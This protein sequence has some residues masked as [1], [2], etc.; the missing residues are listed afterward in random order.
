MQEM[1]KSMERHLFWTEALV[2]SS[3]QEDKPTTLGTMSKSKKTNVRGVGDQQNLALRAKCKALVPVLCSNTADERTKR[4]AANGIYKQF[5]DPLMFFFMRK[6]GVGADSNDLQDLTMTTLEK[7][8]SKVKQYK[9]DQ[10]EFSTWVYRIALN[11]LIDH[12]RNAKGIDVVSVEAM[13]HHNVQTMG[14][15]DAETFEHASDGF[16]PSQIA[17]RSQSHALVRKA[18]GELKNASERRVIELRF[19]E[20]YTY[21]EIAETLD[22]P[23][24]TVKAMIF[25]AKERLQTVLASEL[26]LTY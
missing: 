3:R 18:I 23:M 2:V 17:D 21:E 20:E 26:E 16:D 10:G 22:M 8:F 25:R 13:N 7:A 4:T 6:M 11:T 14:E 5:Y 19:L 9:A 1:Q 12:K 24:G 15:A